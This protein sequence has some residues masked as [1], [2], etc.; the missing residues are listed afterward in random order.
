L[1][2]GE[3]KKLSGDEQKL[4]NNNMLQKSLKWDGERYTRVKNELVV[5]KLVIP[6][7]GG[8][9]GAVS[10]AEIPGSKARASL[11]LFISYSHHDEDIKDEL[12]KHLSPL[13]RLNLIADW[14][15]RKIAPGDK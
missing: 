10:L 12:L 14:H 7:R 6:G 15:D 13:K 5:E 3:L 4:I 9:G 1:F 2:L 11:K 8:P